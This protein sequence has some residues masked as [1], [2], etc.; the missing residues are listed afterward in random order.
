MSTDPQAPFRS[1][2]RSATED[3]WERTLNQIAT[4]VGQLA[5][6]SRLRNVESDRYEH[7][8]LIAVFGN[9]AAEDALRRSHQEVLVSLLNLSLLDQKDDISKYI[10]GLAQSPRRLLSN[11]EKN[12]G[13]E[14]LLPT[15]AS[16]AQRQLF[17]G[18]IRVIIQHLKAEFASVEIHRGS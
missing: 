5:Y 7:H 15:S 16:S 4:K 12:R 13:Y 11:W 9:D 17:E 1:W 8:G 14:A 3:L 10:Q 18:N 2:Q 6:L